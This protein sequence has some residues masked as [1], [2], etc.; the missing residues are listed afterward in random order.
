MNLFPIRKGTTWNWELRFWNDAAKTSAKDVSGHSFAFTAKDKTDATIITLNNA[1]FVEQASTNIRKATISNST[2]SG[3]T[4]QE[5]KYELL[6][7][8]PGGDIELWAE[9]YLNVEA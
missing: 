3:Y 6:V 7:T 9:G 1:A 2:T 5:L 4:A 8:L